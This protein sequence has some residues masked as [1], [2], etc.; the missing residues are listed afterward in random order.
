[1]PFF[2][3]SQTEYYHTVT[4]FAIFSVKCG[5]VACTPRKPSASLRKELRN[6]EFKQTYNVA[7]FAKYIVGKKNYRLVIFRLSNNKSNQN[8]FMLLLQNATY[9]SQIKLNLGI[10]K[11]RGYT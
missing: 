3:G 11:Y 6:Y 2:N 9:I 4:V 8:L 1:M 5:N 7:S 10:P